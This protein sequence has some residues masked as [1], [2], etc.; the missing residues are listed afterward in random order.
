MEQRN[1][2]KAMN[3]ADDVSQAERRRIMAEERRGR[4]YQGVAQAALDD[5]RGGRYAAGS[6][7]KSSVV[8]SSPVS[9]PQQPA[10]SPWA[11]DECPPEPPLG[12]SVDELE[13]VGEPH[14]VEA[15]RTGHGTGSEP[16]PKFR[17]RF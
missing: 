1:A 4:T 6:G 11:K 8:G 13:P 17:R 5:E 9:Y 7:S 10:G 2:G 14:E 16:R 12:Y 3:N 15:S